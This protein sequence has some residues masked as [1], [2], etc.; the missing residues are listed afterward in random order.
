DTITKNVQVINEQAAFTLSSN[1]VCRNQAVVFASSNQPAYIKQYSWQITGPGGYNYT[2]LANPFAINFTTIG[3]YQAVLTITDNNGCTNSSAPQL[4]DVAG[5]VADFTISNNGGCQGSIIR[6]T[7]QSIPAAGS[8]LTGWSWDYGDVTPFGST[9]NSTHSYAS[10]GVYS[11]SLKVTDSRGCF[12]VKTL[13]V[14]ITRPV[15]Y[16]GTDTTLFCPGGPMTFRDSSTGSITAWN[17]A[18]G[19]GGTANTKNP[20]HAYAGGDAVYSVKLIVTDAY[21][22][23]DSL[24]RKDYVTIKKP[25]PAFAVQDSTTICPPLET[26]FTFQG[27]DYESFYWDFGD[28]GSSSLMNPSHFYNTYGSD[29][30]KLYLFGYGGCLDSATSVVSIYNPNAFTAINYPPP[31][32]TCN[33]LTVP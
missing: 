10:T 32:T 7:D 23:S 28:G 26:K 21:G 25:K 24:T 2:T 27:K 1:T 17:W 33:E 31:Y 4:I 3:Q 22:C 5:P 16:F 14:N 11:A 18:F 20:V 19:D 29:T 15:A 30:V 8:T 12:D 9:Q 13:P 6:F